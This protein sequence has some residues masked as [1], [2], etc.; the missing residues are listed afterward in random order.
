MRAINRLEFL[1]S[2]VGV[3]AKRELQHMVNSSEYQTSERHNP[4]ISH[5]S[6]F[7]ERHISY[8]IKHPLVSPAAYL[9]NLRVMTKINR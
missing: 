4:Q 8:L 5:S 7:V 1:K 2:P 9:S 6:K 3:Q